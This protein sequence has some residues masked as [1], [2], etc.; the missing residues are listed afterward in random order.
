LREVCRP[1]V[2][3][4]RV[5]RRIYGP[6]R[7]DVTMEWRKLRDEDLSGLYNSPNTGREM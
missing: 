2:F 3:E 7:D 4:N 5:L 6:K 1:K